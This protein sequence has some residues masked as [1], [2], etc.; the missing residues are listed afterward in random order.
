MFNK[1]Y[2]LVLFS[3]NILKYAVLMLIQIYLLH[4]KDWLKIQEGISG[5]VVEH[6]FHLECI[7][8]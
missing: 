4:Q 8:L 7:F 3:K 2:K 6:V 1:D 5:K